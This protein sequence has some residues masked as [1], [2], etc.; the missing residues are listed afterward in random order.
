VR[1]GLRHVDAVEQD[2]PL[3]RALEAGDHAQTR[4]LAAARWTEQREELARG[5][6]QIDAGDRREVAEAF[7]QIDELDLSA[8]HG[9]GV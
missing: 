8:C 6:V 2:L 1:R 3:A 4:R 7:D 9:R 5:H